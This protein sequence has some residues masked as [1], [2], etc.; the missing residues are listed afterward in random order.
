MGGAV[1]AGKEI[2]G[3]QVVDVRMKKVTA[4]A[5]GLACVLLVIEEEGRGFKSRPL[6]HF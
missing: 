4:A 1:V 2:A 6:C 5:V 3:E